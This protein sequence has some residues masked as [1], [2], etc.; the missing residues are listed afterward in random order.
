MSSIY[1]KETGPGKGRK[2]KELGPTNNLLMT[3]PYAEFLI[4][5]IWRTVEFHFQYKDGRDPQ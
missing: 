4:N 1:L 2:G 3:I 5:R